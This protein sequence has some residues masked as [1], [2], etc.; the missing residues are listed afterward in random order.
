MAW[1]NGFI[2]K[3]FGHWSW[4]GF[5]YDL[6]L[7]NNAHL[8]EYLSPDIRLAAWFMHFLFTQWN[9]LNAY[10]APGIWVCSTEENRTLS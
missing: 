2:I 1:Q 3:D 7:L 9:A 5:N 10:H 4:G 6:T 8:G